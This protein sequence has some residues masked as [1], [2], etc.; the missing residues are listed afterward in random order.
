MRNIKYLAWVCKYKAKPFMANVLSITW[1]IKDLNKIQKVIIEDPFNDRSL[2]YH[3]HEVKLRQYT[4]IKDME[5]KEIYEGDI[6]EYKEHG[7]QKE[8]RRWVVEFGEVEI[9]GIYIDGWNCGT[10]KREKI[11]GNIYENPELLDQQR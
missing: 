11:I 8:G 3:G 9:D 1:D 5:N 6:L 10:S 4:G 7:N 2:R